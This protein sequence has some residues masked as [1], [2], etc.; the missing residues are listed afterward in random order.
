VAGGKYPSQTIHPRSSPCHSYITFRPRPGATAT[1]DGYLIITAGYIRFRGTMQPGRSPAARHPGPGFDVLGLVGVIAQL[2]AH[3]ADDDI[4]DHVQIERLH[5]RGV[6]VSASPNVTLRK[7]DIGPAVSCSYADSC[8]KDLN[9][10]FHQEDLV[11]IQ[12]RRNVDGVP[13]LST[14]ARL[15]DSYLHDLTHAPAT[16]YPSSAG[17]HAD[18]IQL[19]SWQHV[20]IARNRFRRCPD[21]N[22][23]AGFADGTEYKDLRVEHNDFGAVGPYSF[24]GAQ[25]GCTTLRFRA[26]VV[27]GQNVVFGC[28]QTSGSVAIEN[29]VLPDVPLGGCVGVMRRYNFYRS[30]STGLCDRSTEAAGRPK[31]FALSTAVRP[32]RVGVRYRVVA[33]APLEVRL[34]LYRGSRLLAKRTSLRRTGARS[35]VVLGWIG[36]PASAGATRVCVLALDARRGVRAQSC[37]QVQR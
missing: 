22:I 5:T 9:G 25:F 33:D 28:A 14:G 21:T 26:N 16:R 23:F 24:W 7:L 13:R 10:G 27:R 8:A 20:T 1:V 3:A 17:T 6:T 30:G 32:G 4:P 36:S 18:C 29:N 31:A 34:L 11:V 35:G 37:R 2:T 19:F 15:V 12:S